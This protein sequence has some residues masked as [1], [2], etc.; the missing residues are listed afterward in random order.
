MKKFVLFVMLLG[1]GILNYGC[2]KEQPAD[3]PPEQPA[4]EKPAETPAEKPAE[5][6]AP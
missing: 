3:K 2:A 5:T 6:P 4:A 1:A